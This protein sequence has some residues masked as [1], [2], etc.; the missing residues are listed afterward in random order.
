LESNQKE[1]SEHVNQL[2]EQIA[3]LQK[4]LATMREESSAA[5]ARIKELNEAQQSSTRNLSGLNE[6]FVSS[7]TALN[8]LANRVDRKRIDFDVANRDAKQIAPDIYLTLRRTDAGKQEVDATLKVGTDGGNLPIRGQ[9][10]R[11]PVLFYGSEESRPIEMVFTQ[12]S[13]NRVSGYIM[14]PTPQAAAS[15]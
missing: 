14:M 8:T 7:Q 15:Q 3:G 12:V 4:E 10:I 11:K 2:Q 9:G 5:N 6:R 13:K 1:S